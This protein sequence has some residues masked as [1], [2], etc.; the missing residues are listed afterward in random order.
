M[1][2]AG[3]VFTTAADLHYAGLLGILAVLAAVFATFLARTIACRMCTL[4]LILVLCHVSTP[5]SAKLYCL[6]R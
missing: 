2:T 6:C 1:L 5:C 4:I 3:V